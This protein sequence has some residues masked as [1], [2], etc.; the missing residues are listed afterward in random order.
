MDAF[1]WAALS[2]L[3]F[4]FINFV[5]CLRAADWNAVVTQAAA[6]GGGIGVTVLAAHS[7]FGDSLPV[8]NVPLSQLNTPSHILAGLALA[9]L[10]STF[11]E[12]KKAID[13]SDTAVKPPL[14]PG[15]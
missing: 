15:K 2:A 1:S 6:W 4:T 14:I 9:S 5:K 13:G 12:V 3:V 7:D 10:A 11:N 8:A